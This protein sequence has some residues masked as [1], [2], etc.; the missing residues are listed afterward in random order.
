MFPKKFR[1][2]V[3]PPPPSPLQIIVIACVFLFIYFEIQR[4]QA[5][6]RSFTGIKYQLCKI[7]VKNKASTFS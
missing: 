5:T 6:S 4:M 3:T 1:T 7:E 2:G